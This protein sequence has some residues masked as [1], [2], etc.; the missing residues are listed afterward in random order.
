MG[1]SNRGYATARSLTKSKEQFRIELQNRLDAA[2]TIESRRKLGQFS[3]PFELAYNI[4]SFGLNLCNTETPLTFLDPAF[5]TGVFYSSLIALINPDNIAYAKGI[6][7]DEHYGHPSQN[8]WSEKNVEIQIADFT[9]LHPDKKFNFII[10]NPPY[11]RHHLIDYDE[12]I[13]IKEK[14]LQNSG[15]NLSG[16]AGLYCHF[17]LQSYQWMEEDG[18]AGWLI[19][20]EFM[21]VNYGKE[22]K[23]FLLDKVELLRIHRFD[24]DDVQFDDA[25]VSSAVVW[26]KKKKPNDEY[27]IE[28][29]FGGNLNNPKVIREISSKTLKSES[30]WTRFPLMQ[31]RQTES[32]MPRIADYF[33]VKRGIA[34][35][36]N[37]FFIIS[38]QKILDLGLPVEFMRPVLPSARYV[39]EIEIMSDEYGNP[40]ISEEL[41]LIDCRLS[42]NEVQEKYPALWK[43]FEQGRKTVSSGYLCKTRKCWYYQEQ[44]EAPPIVCTYMGREKSN[45]NMA[46]RFILNH[47][48][49][50][51]TNSYLALYPKD[52]LK[53][54]FVEKPEL[55]RCIWTMLNSLTSES[56]TAEGRIYGG[57]LKK[58]E[59]SEL[60]NVPLPQMRETLP[61]NNSQPNWTQL[62]L[63]DS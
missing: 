25:L 43:Y 54:A 47:S 51:V 28:F 12:K 7:I 30:K 58:I 15:E 37:D 49:A 44:R 11:V 14:T 6:E 46:F 19:P 50:V 27:S 36:S 38:K 32:E 9:K 29:S 1:T 35:G 24:P 45:G 10:C 3:T 48:N 33:D 57:G 13:R 63:F 22:I 21:D 18:V 56:I 60:L 62:S 8:L 59:P 52:N 2:K 53:R 39:K 41:F 34:T 55:K 26:F 17:L 16:L 61:P 42:E 31:T 23:R 5:G 4:I 40:I 20:S